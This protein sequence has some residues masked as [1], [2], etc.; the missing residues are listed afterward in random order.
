MLLMFLAPTTPCAEV[1]AQGAA[2]VPVQDSSRIAIQAAS[3][4]ADS[5]S[6]A[7]SA[8]VESEFTAV[9]KKLGQV[10]SR[11]AAIFGNQAWQLRWQR[12]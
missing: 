3:R 6:R 5:A 4:A 8:V 9:I 1:S 10:N 11:E 12:F 2:K 7:A